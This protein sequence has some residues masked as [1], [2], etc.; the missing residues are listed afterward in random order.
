[1]GFK[2]F[3]T[4]EFDK[5]FSKLDS[6]IQRQ[7]GKEI[8]QLAENPFSGKPLGY[9]FFREKKVRGYRIYF[10]IY[11]EY[12]VIFIITISGKKEQQEVIDTIKS[13]IPTIR[14]KS[15][16]NSANLFPGLDSSML[17]VFKPFN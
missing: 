6:Q 1:M 3:T 10:L 11:E 5:I 7:I 8:D 2:I 15:K 4:E 17:Y 13:L 16:I 9:K 14:K 12:L